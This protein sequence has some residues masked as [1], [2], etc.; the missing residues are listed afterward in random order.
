MIAHWRRYL[1]PAPTLPRSLWLTGSGL[2]LALLSYWFRAELWPNHPTAGKWSLAVLPCGMVI[3]VM[4]VMSTLQRWSA[5]VFSSTWLR[6]VIRAGATVAYVVAALVVV[7][8]LVVTLIVL[9]LLS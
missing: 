8:I 6:W 9:A 7:L 4:Q 2:L 1:P 5:A 3:G